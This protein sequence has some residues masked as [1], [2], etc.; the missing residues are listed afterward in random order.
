MNAPY[1]RGVLQFFGI[2]IAMVYKDCVLCF[3]KGNT[4]IYGGD[5]EFQFHV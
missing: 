3:W 1:T 2:E 4:T 5:R